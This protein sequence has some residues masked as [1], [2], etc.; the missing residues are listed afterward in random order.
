MQRR[1]FLP[2]LGAP[3]FGVASCSTE[4][5]APDRHDVVVY[6]GT[7]GGLVSAISAAQAGASVVVV[8]PTHHLGGMVTG[9]LGR[10]DIGVGESIGGAAAEFYRRVKRHYDQPDAWRFQRRD[11]YLAGQSRCVMDDK[12]WYHE[13]SVAS[14]LFEEWIERAG[15]PV[16]TEARLDRVEKRGP[17]IL[18][19]QCGGR[20]FRGRVFIDAT[21]EGDLLAAAGVSYRVGR[22]SSSEYG[23]RFAGVLAREISTRKQWDVDVNPYDENGEL[24]F[25]IQDVER[26][27]IGAGDHKVQ[28][29]NYRIC[30]TDHPDNQVPIEA[31]PNYDPSWYDLLVR[32]MEARGDMPLIKQGKSWGV[33]NVGRLPNRKTDINDGGPFSTDF[34][35]FNWN[36][37]DGDEATRQAILEQH[38]DY[39]RGLLYFCG[40][41]SRVPESIRNEMLRWGYP[42]DEYVDNGHWTPQLYVREARRMVGDYVMTSRDIEEEKTKP[43]SIGMGSYGADSHLVQRIVDNGVVRNEGNPNDFT[44]GHGVY[45]IPY[46]AI[47]PKRAECDNLLSTFC[48]SASHMAFASVRMEPVFMILSESAGVAARTAV[49]ADLAVQDVP[50]DPL[51]DTLRERRQLLSIDDVQSTS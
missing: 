1:R 12:W 40:H 8:E 21:Y 11:E 13:P 2:L 15:V 50:Y 23:E 49:E 35:G 24:L 32:Y 29:Y 16:V 47:T 18:S 31:P 10:T 14:R 41:D 46:R 48:V 20:E 19:I 26:G 3:L 5:A 4:D 25:G 45:E 30:I 33:L 36:Y 42:K 9:G 44:P 38:E 22:E 39:T 37:P 17:R 28:A 43:D 34:I 7:A 51:R 6:G 27:E